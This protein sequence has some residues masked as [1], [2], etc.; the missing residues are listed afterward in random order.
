MMLVNA[1]TVRLVTNLITE[2]SYDNRRNTG[3]NPS[4][5]CPCGHCEKVVLGGSPFSKIESAWKVHVYGPSTGG[6]NK[7]KNWFWVL[8]LDPW[9]SSGYCVKILEKSNFQNAEIYET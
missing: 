4:Q 7:S 5:V 6:P 3:I 9:F 8:T 1:L 2:I